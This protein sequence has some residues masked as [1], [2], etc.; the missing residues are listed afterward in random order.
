MVEMAILRLAG[1]RFV[2]KASAAAD[3]FLSSKQRR[4]E[5]FD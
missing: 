5:E 2:I 3:S 4:V 1:R